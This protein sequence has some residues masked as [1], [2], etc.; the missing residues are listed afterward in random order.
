MKA[1]AWAA[2]AD[3]LQGDWR[4][5]LVGA[6]RSR[7]GKKGQEEPDT[8]HWIG[9]SAN[10]LSLIKDPQHFSARASENV[11]SFLQYDLQKPLLPKLK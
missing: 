5:E 8:H 6:L 3:S 11:P 1:G 9:S 7:Q 4:S 2:E 10:C